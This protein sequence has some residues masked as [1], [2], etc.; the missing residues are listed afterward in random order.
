MSEVSG[1]EMDKDLLDFWFTIADIEYSMAV[2][3]CETSLIP[4]LRTDC[5]RRR[6]LAWYGFVDVQTMVS[7]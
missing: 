4:Y 7:E 5:I 6:L 2:L 1:A 3:D